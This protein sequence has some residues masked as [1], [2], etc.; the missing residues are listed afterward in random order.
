MERL[1]AL[2]GFERRSG[3]GLAGHPFTIKVN[4]RN[5]IGPINAS[6]RARAEA[7]IREDGKVMKCLKRLVHVLHTLS[8]SGVFGAAIGLVYR[9]WS[10]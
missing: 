4:A 9:N 7:C 10:T 6:L 3:A 5:T 8:T 2:E 1:N